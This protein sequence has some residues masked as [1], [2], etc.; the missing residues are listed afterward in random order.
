MN[1]F[2]RCIWIRKDINGKW[3]WGGKSYPSLYI[4]KLAVNLAYKR[5][6]NSIAK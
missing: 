1:I 5:L 6:Q 4:A 2:Y 3:Y